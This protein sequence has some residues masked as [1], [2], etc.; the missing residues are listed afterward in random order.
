MCQKS[1][2]NNSLSI[3]Y[4]K[5]MKIKIKLFDETFFNKKSIKSNNI[6]KFMC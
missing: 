3:I 6:L 5:F 4:Q 1:Q 2:K